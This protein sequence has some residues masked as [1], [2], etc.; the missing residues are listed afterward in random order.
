MEDRLELEL[1][2]GDDYLASV[3]GSRPDAVREILHYLAVNAQDG[4]GMR[5]VEIKRVPFDL[6]AAARTSLPLERS[7]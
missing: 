5:V 7:E 4:G 2:R 1:W 6:V 3:E